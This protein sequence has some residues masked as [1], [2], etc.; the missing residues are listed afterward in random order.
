MTIYR[1][2]HTNDFKL[3]RYTEMLIDNRQLVPVELC[4][5][6]RYDAHWGPHYIASKRGS[7]KEYR[8]WCPGAGLDDS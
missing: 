7:D 3:D 6:N 8:E 4:A 5:H 2:V 1:I